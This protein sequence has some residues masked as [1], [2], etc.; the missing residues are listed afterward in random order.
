MSRRGHWGTLGCI[1][2]CG[3]VGGASCRLA[4]CHAGAGHVV[5]GLGMS[6]G[7]AGVLWHNISGHGGGQQGAERMGDLW[8]VSN[9]AGLDDGGGALVQVWAHRGGPWRHVRHV[10]GH[11]LC[12][13]GCSGGLLGIIDALG[14]SL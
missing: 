10:C 1:G 6:K 12:H 8:D 9:G 5:Q 13:G 3:R 7:H 14:V 2:R 4:A 11:M